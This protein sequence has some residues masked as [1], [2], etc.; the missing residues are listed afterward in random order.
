MS[1]TEIVKPNGAEKPPRRKQREEII[2]VPQPTVRLGSVP[3]T[4]PKEM[5]QKA[6][7]Y[8]DALSEIINRQKLYTNIQGKKY[9]TCEG[10]TTL[11]AMLGVLPVEEYCNPLPD[12]NGYVAKVQLIRTSDGQVIGG[13]SAECTKDESSWKSRNSYALRSMSITR[14]T[15]KAFRLSFSWI[16][17]LAGF[18]ATPAEEMHQPEGSHEAAQDVAKQKI[19][20]LEGKKLSHVPALF[21]TWFNESQTARIEGDHGLMEA[22]RDLLVRFWEPS[23]KAVVCN[24]EQ[25]E[26]LKFALSERNVPFKLLK[27]I[28]EDIEGKLKESIAQVAAK[29]AMPKP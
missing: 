23:V 12:N 16:V 13:A 22:N 7:E 9:V 27:T 25:L 20:E 24:A 2:A 10:W 3:I 8:A 21:Y 1:E 19:A 18:E 14:A 4:N 5:V 6:T 29:K 17:K 15:G 28:G 11:G 26:N